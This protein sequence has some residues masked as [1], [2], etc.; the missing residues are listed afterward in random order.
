M[1]WVLVDDCK[2]P[3]NAIIGFKTICDNAI[4]PHAPISGLLQ[5]SSSPIKPAQTPL[6]KCT[7]NLIIISKSISEEDEKVPYTI[8]T[9]DGEEKT[10]ASRMSC[11]ELI[12]KLGNWYADQL[13]SHPIRT[14]SLSAGSLAIV[15]DVLAQIIEYETDFDDEDKFLDNRRIFAMF[16]EGSCVSGPLLHF[17]FQFYE[18]IFPVHCTDE[19]VDSVRRDQDLTLT[20]SFCGEDDGIAV[21]SDHECQS[22]KRQYLAAFLHVVFD[23]VIMAFPY[24]GG[25]MIVT[26]LVEGH[27]STLGQELKED[28]VNN[29]K[30]SWVAALLLAPSQFC[31][32]RY[33]PIKWRVLAV[34]LQDVL[35]IITM[36]YLT[37]RTRE[38]SEPFFDFAADDLD[39]ADQDFS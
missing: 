16:I 22:N 3:H 13:E 15:G 38:P 24:V 6:H 39:F 19:C 11:A 10:S 28:Y 18:Y 12:S 30:A 27:G 5:P 31:A 9:D 21:A 8:H 37:H 26:S 7:A 1:A 17:A 23:Q 33:L 35:W 14:K 4:T 2:Y 20:S 32:F 29:V 36:S 25:M 34:N